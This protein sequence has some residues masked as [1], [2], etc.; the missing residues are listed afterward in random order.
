MLLGQAHLLVSLLLLHLLSYLSIYL[1]LGLH[2]RFASGRG[3]RKGTQLVP[4]APHSPKPRGGGGVVFPVHSARVYHFVHPVC[5]SASASTTNHHVARNHHQRKEG[6]RSREERE[7]EETR[8]SQPVSQPIS[9]KV[10]QLV[11]P[12]PFLSVSQPIPVCTLYLSPGL[13]SS[14]KPTVVCRCS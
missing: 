2:T 3:P 7:R 12:C 5:A 9:Q 1:S 6:R 11:R 13:Q 14:N 10:S 4:G 8:T